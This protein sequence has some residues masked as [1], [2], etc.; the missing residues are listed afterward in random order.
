MSP[1]SSS[2]AATGLPTFW[3][4]PVFSATLRVIVPLGNTGALLETAAADVSQMGNPTTVLQDCPELAHLYSV[5]PL[6]A[7]LRAYCLTF[8]RCNVQSEAALPGALVKPRTRVVPATWMLS[9]V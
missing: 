5:P 1:V 3:P 9:I 8:E 2:V 4:E 6:V 7:A